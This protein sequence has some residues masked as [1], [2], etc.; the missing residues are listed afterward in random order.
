MKNK[1]KN[2]HR[3]G[4]NPVEKVYAQEWE[5][6]NDHSRGVLDL[7]LAEKVNCPAG[8]VSDRDREVAATVI[9]WLGSPVGQDFIHKCQTTEPENMC[10]TCVD[11][12]THRNCPAFGD[13]SCPMFR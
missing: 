12:G 6:I 9:Q 2:Q 7:I 11:E 5:K 10:T 3:F 1:G 13:A 8:E 4:Q